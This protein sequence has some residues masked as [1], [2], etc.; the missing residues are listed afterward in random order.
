[1]FHECQDRR[2]GVGLGSAIRDVDVLYYRQNDSGLLTGLAVEM[3][4]LVVDF[5]WQSRRIY[6]WSLP[7]GWVSRDVGIIWRWSGIC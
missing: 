1:M 7:W 2:C 4:R 3:D 5:M 6:G